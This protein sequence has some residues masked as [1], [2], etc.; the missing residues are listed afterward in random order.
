MYLPRAQGDAVNL[1]DFAPYRPFNKIPR[2]HSDV[3]VT[4]KI[5]GTNACIEFAGFDG[6]FLM[7]AGSRNRRLVTIRWEDALF[8]VVK[9]EGKGDN[10]GFGDWVVRNFLELRGLGYGAHFGEWWGQG[11]QRT[12]GLGEKRFSLFREPKTLPAC[13]SVVPR[14]ATFSESFDMKRLADLMVTLRVSG[15]VAA[16]G[17]MNPE[18]IVA[19]HVRSGQLFKLTYE[20]GPKGQANDD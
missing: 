7:A 20:A 14:L 11:I 6:V 13:C 19:F 10:A 18:G 1:L 15:S 4:E 5:D 12:Y 17:F 16:P 2:L 3:I 8:P 9:W